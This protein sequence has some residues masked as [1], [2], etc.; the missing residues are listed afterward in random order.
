MKRIGVFSGTFD[1]FHNA[2]LEACLVAKAACELDTVLIMIEKRPHRKY[3]VTS[4]K[5]RVNMVD[6]ATANFPSLRM[7]GTDT[8]NINIDNILPDL[9]E[10]FVD[11]EY[12]LIIGS[13]TVK[14]LS[15]WHNIEK[16]F[17][18]FKICV[19]LRENKDKK[20]V[21]AELKKLQK[22]FQ[23][24]VYKLLPEVWSPVASSK[25]RRQIKDTGYSALIHHDVLE[26]IVKENIY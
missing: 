13:D 26:Y 17:K 16:V 25:I 21:T 10:Q 22:E 15:H 2:H 20:T 12:W 5:K 23:D 8:D 1:P 6:L 11:G 19:I 3:N 9:R 18:Y 7:F 24:F 4:Y 14:Y